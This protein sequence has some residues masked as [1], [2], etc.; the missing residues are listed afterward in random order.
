M[1]LDRTGLALACDRRTF[2]KS[3]AALT[4][5]A[6][7]PLGA[8]A[9]APATLNLSPRKKKPALIRGAFF[10]PPADLVLAG[11]NEDGWSKHEWFTWPGNQFA[12]EQQQTK[13]LAQLRRLTAGLDLTLALEEKPLYTDAAIRAFIAGLETSKPAA[14]LLFNFYNT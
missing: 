8:F 4:G 14:L 7:W 6:L 5:A 1:T 9:S 2:I 11:K 10:Y 3:A 13:F 12:P